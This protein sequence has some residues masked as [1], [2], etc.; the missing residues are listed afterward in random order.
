MACTDQSGCDTYRIVVTGQD[1]AEILVTPAQHRFELPSVAVG[2]GQRLAQSLTAAMKDLWKCE[3][4]CLF[5]PGVP[6]VREQ[7]TSVRYQVMQGCRRSQESEEGRAQWIPVWRL[8]SDSFADPADYEVVRQCLTPCADYARVATPGPFAR[9]GWFNELRDW[10]QEVIG[11]M[12][13]RL[14]G[15][16]RQFNA[17]PTFS[18]IR[19]ET[20]GPALWFKAVGEPNVREFFL[21]QVLAQLIPTYLPQV[22][23]TRPEWHGWLAAEIGGPKLEA[24]R[25]AEPWLAAAKAL[26]SLQ[27]GSIGRHTQLLERG[28]RDLRATTLSRRLQPFFSVMAE[29]M[30][31]QD[32]TPPPALTGQELKHLGERLKDALS[33]L[34][35]LGIPD[36]LGNLDLN[37]AN[38]IVAPTGCR[39]LDWAEAFVGHPFFS[40]A[41]LQEH[42]R[43]AIGSAAAR[44]DQL[45]AAYIEVWGALFPAQSLA[46]ALAI[47]PMLA[48][49]A[50]A[51]GNDIWSDR[52]RHQ[53][54]GIEGYLRSLTRRIK[55]EADLL[56]NGRSR[57]QC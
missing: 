2:P 12:G 23:A 42:F 22:L 14:N 11:P 27:A 50:Y 34:E 45:V 46:R 4:V 21:T 25:T 57:W 41:Y 37:P 47:A 8:S 7:S 26:A 19:F 40:L 56:V 1:G 44:D 3:A 10:V 35:E 39:F 18:L 38:I 52:S 13:L 49:F 20:N 29:L 15:N 54:P 6:A 33:L 31:Q 17:S 30:E 9:A 36:T 28:A 53:Q 48:V 32:K 16:F 43:R 5:S 51:A 24:M 55:R